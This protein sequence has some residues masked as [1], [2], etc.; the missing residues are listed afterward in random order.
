MTTNEVH[1]LVALYVVDAL[2]DDE[3]RHFEAHLAGCAECQQE[4]TEMREVTERLSRSVASEPPASLRSSVLSGIA[5]M[6]QEPVAVERV[7]D[8]TAERPGSAVDNVVPLRPRLST[9]LPLLVAA[10]AVLFALGFGGWALQSRNDAQEAQSQQSELVNLLAAGDVRT[11]SGSVTGGGS[12]TV[13]LSRTRDQAVFVSTELPALPDDRVYELW[14]IKRT[15]QPAG[16]F[17]PSDSGALVTLP[18]AALSADQIA[19]TVE[20]K[21]GSEQPTSEPVLAVDVPRSS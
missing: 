1:D 4:V 17:T 14:T 8:T 11:V 2:S 18:T 19:V 9:R 12:G 3:S 6:A 7:V 20:P 21:G 15:P 16:T 10:A 5:G 13:V